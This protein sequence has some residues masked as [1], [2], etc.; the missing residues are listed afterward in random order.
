MVL[1]KDSILLQSPAWCLGLCPGIWLGACQS[2][3]TCEILAGRFMGAH[4]RTWF[5][6]LL[7]LRSWRC[8]AILPCPSFTI[9]TLRGTRCNPLAPM[10]SAGTAPRGH[11]A[12]VLTLAL[13]VMLCAGR[14]RQPHHHSS[15]WILNHQPLII[16][17][18]H[19]YHHHHHHHHHP[20]FIIIIIIT[21]IIFF[22]LVRSPLSST[23]SLI[24]VI[25]HH[26][27]S[28]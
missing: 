27:L 13:G 18:D 22:F 24:I 21:I 8:D 3:E 25:N 28:S 23:S 11:V 10:H 26:S 15:S 16:N 2:G 5:Q 7:V 14:W 12:D 1:K 9:H 6:W 4:G 20:S 17:H 19:H